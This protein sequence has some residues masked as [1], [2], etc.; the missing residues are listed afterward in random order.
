MKQTFRKYAVAAAIAAVVMSLTA[1]GG[2]GGGGGGST[3]GGTPVAATPFARVVD[4]SVSKT[5][6]AP[7][8]SFD[9]SF[10]VEYE[11]SFDTAVVEL[12]VNTTDTPD[13]ALPA[14]ADTSASFILDS[15]CTGR[16]IVGGSPNP[17]DNCTIT[18][19]TNDRFTETGVFHCTFELSDQAKPAGTRRLTCES[20]PDGFAATDKGGRD[21]ARI[22]TTFAIIGLCAPLTQ[23]DGSLGHVCDTEARSMTFM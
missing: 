16:D 23:S 4:M 11:S 18:A 19:N 9:V 7:G 3:G 10:T 6:V 1:C 8:E 22:G 20:A 21:P 13:A 5:T 12:H 17:V 15:S 2:G 14:S